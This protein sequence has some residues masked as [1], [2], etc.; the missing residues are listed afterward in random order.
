MPNSGEERM[1]FS[2]PE[3]AHTV[4][5]QRRSTPSSV[6]LVRGTCKS[7]FAPSRNPCLLGRIMIT[8]DIMPVPP[9][10]HI[11]HQYNIVGQGLTI[12]RT[13][14]LSSEYWCG[15]LRALH[16]IFPILLLLLPFAFMN[17]YRIHE[18]EERERVLF[19]DRLY[20]TC[21][22]V[23]NLTKPDCRLRD[24]LSETM[25]A[26]TALFVT[27]SQRNGTTRQ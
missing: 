12:F 5:L 27:A 17:P 6:S 22:A 19:L 1:K 7:R 8:P 24:H 23:P 4:D 15:E 13:A 16:L 9:M 26:E 25:T 20:I 21:R 2:V 10:L 14:S 11:G 3:R 18:F